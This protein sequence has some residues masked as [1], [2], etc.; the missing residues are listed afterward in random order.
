MRSSATGWRRTRAAQRCLALWACLIASA[1]AWASDSTT[2]ARYLGAASCA[3]SAC[4]GST[5]GFSGSEI[6]HD[7]YLIWQRRDRHSRAYLSLLTPASEAIAAALGA[8]PAHEDPQCLACHASAGL[9]AEQGPRFQI[10]D[11]VDCETC[12]GP[13]SDWIK[14]HTAGLRSEAQ[15]SE[16][17]LHPTWNAP[18]RAQLCVSCHIGDREHP[19]SHAVMAAGHPPLNFELDT[20]LA[21]MPPHH[22]PEKAAALGKPAT[23]PLEHWRVGQGA[24][25]RVLL[26]R[27]HE[28]AESPSVL[29]D[30]GLFDCYACHHD[31][32]LSRWQRGRA[33]GL[34][35]GELRLADSALMSLQLWL[36]AGNSEWAKDWAQARASLNASL[37]RGNPS[38]LIKHR[39]QLLDLQAR[40]P[41]RLTD[42]GGELDQI[43][44]LIQV[45]GTRYRSD[46]ALAQQAAMLAGVLAEQLSTGERIAGAELDSALET[47][48][49]SVSD[50]LAFEPERYANAN[51]RFRMLAQ[52]IID[53]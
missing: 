21:V 2:P 23:T 13:A 10:R 35:V 8:V 46:F 33:P 16:Q 40:I 14:T 30:F 11:G 1:P 44:K 51:Y 17:D 39:K 42:S 25:A 6:G 32:Q 18:D 34:Q 48:R 45:A 50:S 52:S 41:W 43:M 7:E 3:S 31:L 24:A 22:R 4:H 37:N 12:H 20:Y 29:P 53:N 15:R 49:D 5:Q 36:D 26:E 9:A 47:L 28:L 19:I 27:V 38:E